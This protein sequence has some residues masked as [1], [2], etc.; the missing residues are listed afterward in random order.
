MCSTEAA[1]PSVVSAAASASKVPV[2]SAIFSLSSFARDVA[3]ALIEP[4]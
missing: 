1:N 3:K 4:V 2:D